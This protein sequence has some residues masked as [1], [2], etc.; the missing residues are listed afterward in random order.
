MVSGSRA[1]DGAAAASGAAVATATTPA[2]AAA[3]PAVRLRRF[4]LPEPDDA[5]ALPA[6]GSIQWTLP[7]ACF[8]LYSPPAFLVDVTRTN[9]NR[10]LA[11]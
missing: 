7:G 8:P 4:R 10:H 1:A 5:A 3:R 11:H 9:R 6:D 2:T